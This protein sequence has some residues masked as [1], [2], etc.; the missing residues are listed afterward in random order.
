VLT[1]KMGVTL[2]KKMKGCYIH[3][4]RIR[5]R[6]LLNRFRFDDEKRRNKGCH[7]TL[8][9]TDRALKRFKVGQLSNIGV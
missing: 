2:N 4:I 7:A 1:V 6:I 9:T 5:K 8:A 3:R